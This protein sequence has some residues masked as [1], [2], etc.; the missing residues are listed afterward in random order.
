MGADIHFIVEQRIKSQRGKD[1]WIGVTSSGYNSSI[2]GAGRFYLF[3]AALAGVR[4][5]GPKPKGHPKNL[6]DLS[7]IVLKR[8]DTIADA[9]SHTHYSADDFCKLYVDCIKKN[10]PEFGARQPWLSSYDIL[11]ITSDEPDEPPL[12][13]YRVIIFFDN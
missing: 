7:R 10:W 9:H 6:S 1:R 2:R 13:D 11:G 5:P 3:F 8:W 4:G 12:S